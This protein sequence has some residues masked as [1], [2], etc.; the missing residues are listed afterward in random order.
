MLARRILGLFVI[1]TAVSCPLQSSGAKQPDT[2]Y[3]QVR[4]QEPRGDAGTRTLYVKDS[5]YSGEYESAGLK[6]KLVKNKDGVFLL[7]YIRKYAAKYPPGTSRETP[8]CIVP[9]P[10]GDVK[11]YLAKNDAKKIGQ[12]TVNGK[13]CDMYT[14]KDKIG[15]W[16]CKFWAH[17][18]TLLPVKL[19]MNGKKPTDIETVTYVTYKVGLP[20]PDSRFEV[21]KDYKIGKMP[22]MPANKDAAPKP[23]EK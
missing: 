16:N 2:C 3:F 1:V 4:L 17:A 11:Q 20:I 12:E 6:W 22:A 23:A 19:V 13:L 5:Y 18:K 14:Y 8:A 10:V 21:P 9:G 15:G 7:N